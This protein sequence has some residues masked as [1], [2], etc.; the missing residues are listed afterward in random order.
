[1]QTNEETFDQPLGNGLQQIPFE[2]N[3]EDAYDS[4]TLSLEM[5]Q[6]E[7][8]KTPMLRTWIDD[9]YDPVH[10]QYLLDTEAQNVQ[11]EGNLKRQ[12]QYGLAKGHLCT[13]KPGLGYFGPSVHNLFAKMDDTLLHPN[14]HPVSH[15]WDSEVVAGTP[16]G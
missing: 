2:V 9:Q 15:L 11:T 4:K 14:H 13:R 1:M 7:H 5:H 3:H 12:N 6:E 10:P 16:S 8:F